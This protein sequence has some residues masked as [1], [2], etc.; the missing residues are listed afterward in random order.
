MNTRRTQRGYT[1]LVVMGLLAV[2]TMSSAAVYQRAENSLNMTVAA[3]NHKIIEGRAVS[4]AREMIGRIRGSA[5][6]Q[7]RLN[8]L[9]V[10]P[11]WCRDASMVGDPA[12][13]PSCL[14]NTPMTPVDRRITGDDFLSVTYCN[15]AGRDNGDD[16]CIPTKEG[17]PITGNP[18]ETPDHGYGRLARACIWKKRSVSGNVSYVMMVEGLWGRQGFVWDDQGSNAK[19]RSIVI[20]EFS[21][22]FSFESGQN[23]DDKSSGS[24]GTA[25]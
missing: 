21:G 11:P 1:L 7:Q 16:R 17:M 22:D 23:V 5:V 25:F 12:C 2:M 8:L 13:E 19:M 20:S 4:F 3:R 24:G 9:T 18:G 6:L 10:Y 15:A 14:P